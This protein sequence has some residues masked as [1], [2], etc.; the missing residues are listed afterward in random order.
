[1][2]R[3]TVVIRERAGEVVVR[4]RDVSGDVRLEEVVPLAAMSDAH[5]VAMRARVAALASPP[6]AGR[7]G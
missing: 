4:G 7:A 5:V 3:V 6:D 2:P 1:M